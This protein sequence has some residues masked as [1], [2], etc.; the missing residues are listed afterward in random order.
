M[1]GQS[2]TWKTPLM[3]VHWCESH[4]PRRGVGV[5]CTDFYHWITGTSIPEHQKLQQRWI[6]QMNFTKSGDS[7]VV[8]HASNTAKLERTLLEEVVSLHLSCPQHI[9][10]SW[11]ITV[12]LFPT[13]TLQVL[14]LKNLGVRGT[15]ENVCSRQKYHKCFIDILYIKQL[16]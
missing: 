3:L 2:F 16:H 4:A 8:Q 1:T 11:R 5:H 6:K 13:R 14:K 15:N 10:Q 7:G 12:D 9:S